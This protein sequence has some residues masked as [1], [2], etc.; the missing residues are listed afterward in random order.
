MIGNLLA[1]S[2]MAPWAVAEIPCG[3]Y[4]HETLQLDMIEDVTDNSVVPPVN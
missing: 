3:S 4:T 2:T 1:G